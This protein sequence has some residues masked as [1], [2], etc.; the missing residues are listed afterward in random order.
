MIFYTAYIDHNNVTVT[1]THTY[2]GLHKSGKGEKKDFI[3][4]LNEEP[5]LDQVLNAPICMLPKHFTIHAGSK[6]ELTKQLKRYYKQF[7][8]DY[9]KVT[10][11]WPLF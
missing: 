4:R 10:I 5:E 6:Q 3:D 7:D 8:T 11:E 1:K 2:G 9:K